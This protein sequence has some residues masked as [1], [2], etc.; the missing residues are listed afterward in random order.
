MRPGKQRRRV[1]LERKY[2]EEE[3][4][5]PDASDTSIAREEFLGRALYNAPG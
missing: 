1:V 2:G 5:R 4:R 3:R